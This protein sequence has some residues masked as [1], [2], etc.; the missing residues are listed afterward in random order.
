MNFYKKLS[1]QYDTVAT[2]AICKEYKFFSE[3][4]QKL[5]N[6]MSKHDQEIFPFDVRKINLEKYIEDYVL[7]IRK[8]ILK[9]DQSDEALEVA[10]R[11][12]ER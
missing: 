11:S 9:E 5:I 7:G 1:K 3:N 10:R 6:S 12:M 2:V 4:P 8:F